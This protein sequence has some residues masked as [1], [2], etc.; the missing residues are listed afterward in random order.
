MNQ[1][2]RNARQFE[3]VT[4]AEVLQKARPIE[5]DESVMEPFETGA[6][7]LPTPSETLVGAGSGENGEK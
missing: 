7:P 5:D 6:S 1:M 3:V 4:V 2:K